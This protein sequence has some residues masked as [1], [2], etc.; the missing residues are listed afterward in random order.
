MNKKDLHAV[1]CHEKLKPYYRQL[2]KLETEQSNQLLACLLEQT[3]PLNFDKRGTCH[4]DLLNSPKFNYT[5][6][7]MKRIPTNCFQGIKNRIER[8]CGILKDCCSSVNNCANFE[9]SEISTKINQLKLFIRDFGKKCQLGVDIE[10]EFSL[11]EEE[12]DLIADHQPTGNINITIRNPERF[13]KVAASSVT[14]EGRVLV[15]VIPA[16]EELERLRL[17][18]DEENAK[19]LQDDLEK[20]TG[21]TETLVIVKSTESPVT[22]RTTKRLI[23]AE[24]PPRLFTTSEPESEQDLVPLSPPK[25]D[26]P[27]TVQ[28]NK[29]YDI[30]DELKRFSKVRTLNRL[31]EHYK[32]NETETIAKPEN[33]TSETFPTP[34]VDSEKLQ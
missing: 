33:S 34:L 15:R 7:K 3:T 21:F 19:K 11:D 10:K 9:K 23:I 32:D 13:S 18:G 27:K 1:R 8:Q 22:Q 20:V 4:K 12:T 5:G 6:D 31:V 30:T 2:E 28:T 24:D 17:E 14:P 29:P 26:P 25:V 16:E